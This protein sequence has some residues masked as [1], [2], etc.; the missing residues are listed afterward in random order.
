MTTLLIAVAVKTSARLKPASLRPS[1]NRSRS[2]PIASHIGHNGDGLI[3]ALAPPH[4]DG[5]LFQ[6]GESEDV[7]YDLDRP[8]PLRQGPGRIRRRDVILPLGEVGK[9]CGGKRRGGIPRVEP[10]IAGNHVER[11]RVSSNQLDHLL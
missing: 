6:V 1:P 2:L 7:L 3:P 4:R 10:I 8:P 11:L 5:Y 9:D